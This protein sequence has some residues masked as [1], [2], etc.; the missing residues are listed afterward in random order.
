VLSHIQCC[1]SY[2]AA[3]SGP[4]T[5]DALPDRSPPVVVPSVPLSLPYWYAYHGSQGYSPYLHQGP[6]GWPMV[7]TPSQGDGARSSGWGEGMNGHAA[8]S[9]GSRFMAGILLLCLAWSI[10]VRYAEHGQPVQRELQLSF[11]S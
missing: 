7:P 8:G 2:H 1:G 5:H 4:A 9:V 6:D 10:V 3:R 11:L